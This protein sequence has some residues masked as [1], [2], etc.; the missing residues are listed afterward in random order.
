MRVRPSVL[1]VTGAYFPELSG[2]GLQARAVVRALADRVTFSVLTTSTDPSLLRRTQ[3]DGVP[4]RRVFVDPRSAASQLRAAAGLAIS[5]IRSSRRFDIVNLHGFSRKGIL[6][7]VLSRLLRKKFILTLQ[8]G[9]HDEP[10]GV[11]A[12]GRLAYWAY[13]QADLYISVS[14]GLSRAY[15][16]AGLPA[17]RLRP[18][19]NAVDTE[20]FRP[21]PSDERAGLRRDLG[22][23]EDVMIVLFVGFFS[24]DKR[25]D[26]VY[27]AWAQT[28]TAVAS[29]LLFV[30]ATSSAYHEVDRRL[31][32]DIRSR[33]AAAGL[34]D[35][36]MFVES[37]R[38]IEKYFR[39]ADVYVLPSIRE[40]FPVALLEAMAS[41]LPC[42]ATRLSGSTDVIVDDAVNGLL[43]EPDDTAGFA[44]CIRAVLS[45]R[46]LAAR[47]G[48]AA[49]D[50]V[51]QR[52]SM[53][54][55]ARAWL[56]AYRE[57]ATRGST[58]AVT[59]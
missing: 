10:T 29:S 45:D 3:E 12:L 53:E 35:R 47:L 49:R 30:G 16:D 37:S 7:V 41:G 33:A 36:V 21:A 13:R 52:F 19:S 34:A 1:M 20:R 4:I 54:R 17:A 42:V 28:T 39:A 5:F 6:L 8:T 25:P 11:R 57:L 40:G 22:L 18:I 51:T 9:V 26:L 24:R 2:G 27:D 58:A 44:G 31:A 23:R 56:A 46:H 14:P 59:R 43:V 15:H 32:D 48:S 50:T 55:T 38:A